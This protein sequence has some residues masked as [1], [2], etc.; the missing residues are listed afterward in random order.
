M[1]LCTIN[2][3][4]KHCILISSWFIVSWS[5]LFSKWGQLNSPI[6]HNIIAIISGMFRFKSAK[7]V[8]YPAHKCPNIGIL[9]L[10]SRVN[11]ILSK[12][13]H[14]HSFITFGPVLVLLRFNVPVGVGGG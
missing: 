5:F 10:I 11:F 1:K 2:A 12:V 4:L 8:I 7:A 6:I 13:E 14:E 9:T 3:I